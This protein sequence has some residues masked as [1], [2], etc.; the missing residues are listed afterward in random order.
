MMRMI[1]ACCLVLWLFGPLPAAAGTTEVALA[2]LRAARGVD[3]LLLVVGDGAEPSHATVFVC[4]R[5]NGAW[6]EIFRTRARVGKNGIVPAKNKREGDGATPA[7]A[8]GLAGAF[9]LREDPGSLLPYT[10]IQDGDVWV[11]DP[12]SSRYNTM[13][14]AD[15]PDK[16]WKSAENLAGQPDVYAHALVIAYNT[17]D[18]VPGAGSAIFLHCLKSGPTAGC[19]AVPEG[20]MKR[21]LLFADAATRIVIIPTGEDLPNY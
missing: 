18:R 19:V 21:L 7:G 13:T 10:R 2:G 1:L 9:G 3:K 14:K 5:E 6:R 11:D 12:Q 20:D 15:A 17:R 4:A 8:Y 16:D